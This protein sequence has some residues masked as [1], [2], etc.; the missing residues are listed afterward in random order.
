MNIQYTT[1]VQL[2]RAFWLQHPYLPHRRVKDYSGKGKMWPTDTRCTFND[3][4]DSLQKDGLISEALADRA[5][6]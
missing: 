4:L 6:L 5:T 2:R 3:W 1:Q